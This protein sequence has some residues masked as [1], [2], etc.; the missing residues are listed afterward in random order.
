M[1]RRNP[2]RSSFRSAAKIIPALA[3]LLALPSL[4]HAVTVT[5]TAEVIKPYAFQLEG[6][7]VYLFGVDSMEQGQT[8]R[9]D[10]QTWE[11]WAAAV[12]EL[13]TIVSEGEV[14]CESVT[15]P[16]AE[17][18][19]IA[20]CTVN[21]EDIGERFVRSGFGLTIPTET[22]QYDEAQAEARDAGLGLWQSLFTPPAVWRAL[23]M[24][25]KSD[26]PPYV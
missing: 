6:Y 5:G 12:R 2:H 23:P 9:I 4:A 3:M 7:I 18:R 17:Q 24:R 26:R 14:T 15:E 16:N 11:C 20:M 10:N 13:E 19:M 22:T 1:S 8:C 25:P 21:G